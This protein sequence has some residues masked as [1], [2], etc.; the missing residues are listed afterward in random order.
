MIYGLNIK[1][2]G[3]RNHKSREPQ[4]Q[5]FVAINAERPDQP[6]RANLVANELGICAAEMLTGMHTFYLSLD[7]DGFKKLLIADSRGVNAV[8]WED[9]T[10]HDKTAAILVRYD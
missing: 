4:K 10:Y 8:R 6:I 1:R 2:S 3:D 5:V 7:T 9:V